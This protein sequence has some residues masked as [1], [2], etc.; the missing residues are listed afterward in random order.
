VRARRDRGPGGNA[1]RRPGAPAARSTRPRTEG[2]RLHRADRIRPATPPRPE[3]GLRPGPRRHRRLVLRG[4]QPRRSPDHRAGQASGRRVDDFGPVG[5]MACCI[6][7]A[8]RR[9]HTSEANGCSGRNRGFDQ[10][11]PPCWKP[12]AA[13]RFT[14]S[15]FGSCRGPECVRTRQVNL[16]PQRP[17]PGPRRVPSGSHRIGRRHRDGSPDHPYGT[18]GRW[19]AQ[20]PALHCAAPSYGTGGCPSG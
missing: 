19:R 15:F 1:A 20:P 3:P 13:R 11:F 7:V 18:I 10:R 12:R 4:V 14:G 5:A 16:P 9:T 6:C 2:C 17:P 8:W